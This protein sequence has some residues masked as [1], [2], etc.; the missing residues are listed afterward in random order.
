MRIDTRAAQI[1]YVVVVVVVVI[2]RES[3]GEL[4][5]RTVLQIKRRSSLG[6]VTREQK[7]EIQFEIDTS[8]G[9]SRN[10]VRYA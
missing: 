7:R 1:A 5:Q 9:H 4:R 6:F 10:D 8:R 3:A 2:P